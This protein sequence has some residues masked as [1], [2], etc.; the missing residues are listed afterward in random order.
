MLDVGVVGLDLAGGGAGGVE[1]FNLVPPSADGTGDIVCRGW[2]AGIKGILCMPSWSQEY[3]PGPQ[4]QA[5]RFCLL[6]YHQR[7]PSLKSYNNAL[8]AAMRLNDKKWEASGGLY[9]E[10]GDLVPESLRHVD[11]TDNPWTHSA[12]EHVTRTPGIVGKYNVDG[13]DYYLDEGIWG[14]HLLAGWGHL[15]TETVSTAWAAEK[16]PHAPLILIPWGRIWVAALPR[17]METLRL[18][19]WDE[20]PIVVATGDIAL[21]RVHVPERLVNIRALMDDGQLIDP[22]LNDVYDRM[23]FR[24][25][26]ASTGGQK[27]FLPRPEGHKRGHPHELAVEQALINDGYTSVRGW[28]MTVKEQVSA[29]NSAAV[30][31][32][33]TGSNLHNSVFARRGVRVVEIRDSRAQLDVIEGVKRIQGPLCL[34]RDQPFAQVDGYVRHRPRPVAEIVAEVKALVG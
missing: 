3:G 5:M 29:V 17:I 22:A 10:S 2:D 4:I 11:R 32:G 25:G 28:D 6:G 9:T 19:G 8:L 23:I 18:A 33:F 14:G 16:L 27:I 1:D 31:T 12:Q 26:A 20:R 34:L 30:L 21:G 13:V 7:M 15:I 24:S